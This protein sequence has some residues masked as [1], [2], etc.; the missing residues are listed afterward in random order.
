MDGVPHLTQKPIAPGETF[1]YEFDVPDAGTYWYHP[2]QRGFEQVGRGLYGALIIEEREPVAVDRDIIWM[3]GDWRLG[4]DAQIVDD[5][6]NRMEMS[7][8]GRIGKPVTINRQLPTPL[9][10]R[11][12]ERVRLRL[13]NAR[14]EEHTS[15][16]QS[17][18][19]HTF[20]VLCC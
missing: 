19:R 5:F 18:M 15:E 4:D 20:A 14:S 12:G 10:V 3:L 17:L 13:F 9:Q 6:G 7:M 16:L 11:S 1:L 8:A 2:H